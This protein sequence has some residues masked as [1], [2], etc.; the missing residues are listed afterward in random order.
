MNCIQDAYRIRAM[1]WS[2]Q[3]VARYLQCTPPLHGL[4][5]PGRWSHSDITLYIS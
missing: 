5:S 1:A 4:L 2:P 3:D